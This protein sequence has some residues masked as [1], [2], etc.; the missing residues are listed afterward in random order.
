MAAGA[1]LSSFLLFFRPVEN[2]L[3]LP[4]DLSGSITFAQPVL[5]VIADGAR[6]IQSDDLLGH[7]RVTYRDKPRRGIEKGRKQEGRD[8]VR[9]SRDGRRVFFSLHATAD[10]DEFR[11]LVA[12]P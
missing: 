10:P 4:V 2:P 1:R 12:A 11:V 9:I 3:T 5:G 6:L 8:V 7:P